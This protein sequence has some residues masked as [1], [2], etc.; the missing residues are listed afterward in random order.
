MKNL[1]YLVSPKF[2]HTEYDKIFVG[3]ID[4]FIFIGLSFRIFYKFCVKGRGRLFV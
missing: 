2:Y 3:F 1:F 4:F